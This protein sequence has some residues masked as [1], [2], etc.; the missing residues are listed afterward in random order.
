[1]IGVREDFWSG[2]R[3]GGWAAHKQMTSGSDCSSAQD[4]PRETSVGP[5]F[6]GMSVSCDASA[7]APPSAPPSLLL[8]TAVVLHAVESSA[9]GRPPSS[10]SP[11]SPSVSGFQFASVSE[12]R[13]GRR[14][15]RGRRTGERRGSAVC[16][17]S[18]WL[19]CGHETR[20]CH[21][22]WYCCSWGGYPGVDGR[23]PEEGARLGPGE[24][25][26]LIPAV[27]PGVGLG[28]TMAFIT[29]DGGRL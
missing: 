26:V 20:C 3:A 11:S 6:A 8:P 13:E 5:A 29:A 25:G 24:M 23:E 27:V 28:G 14:S 21:S 10:S 4:R 9:A 2:G 7:S 1:M 22:V 15:L 16:P 18:G 19:I 17:S 12:S